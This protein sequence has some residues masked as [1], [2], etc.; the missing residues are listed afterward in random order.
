MRVTEGLLGEGKGGG[1]GSTVCVRRSSS[2]ISARWGGRNEARVRELFASS[3][4]REAKRRRTRRRRIRRRRRRTGRRRVRE[5]LPPP[6]LSIV[7]EARAN[8]PCRAGRRTFAYFCGMYVFFM[9]F[10]A[11]GGR[12]KII[13][14]LLN[15]PINLRRYIS[16]VRHPHR[17]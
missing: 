12:G 17:L 16:C 10:L 11:A 5:L 3:Y 1:G 2:L 15:N 7:D 4:S 9:L 14:F 8:D 6:P 13:Q